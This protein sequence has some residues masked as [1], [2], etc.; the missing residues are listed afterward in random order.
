M[1]PKDQIGRITDCNGSFLDCSFIS[2][3]EIREQVEGTV[4]IIEKILA[5]TNWLAQEDKMA[6][7][8][9]IQAQ[10][11]AAE[12]CKTFIDQRTKKVAEFILMS[13]SKTPPG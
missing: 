2:F 13:K 1:G 7:Y 8:D 12:E 3:S 5:R 9:W 4:E 11:Q 10:K 6:V